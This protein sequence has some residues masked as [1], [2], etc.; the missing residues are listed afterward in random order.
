MRGRALGSEWGM[1]GMMRP[2]LP[3]GAKIEYD[4]HTA[5]L[6]AYVHRHRHKS[7]YRVLPLCALSRVPRVSI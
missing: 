6:H 1:V 3:H 7:N 4:V 2:L 5:Y